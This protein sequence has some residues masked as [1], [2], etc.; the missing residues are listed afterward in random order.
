VTALQQAPH[1]GMHARFCALAT[2]K[3]FLR[4]QSYTLPQE[5]EQSQPAH[6]KL[7]VI[8]SFYSSPKTSDVI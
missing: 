2:P 1:L 7:Y 3:Y 5:I 8:C 4:Q 6:H